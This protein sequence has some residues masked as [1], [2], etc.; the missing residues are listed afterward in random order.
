M[1]HIFIVNP[2]SG[3]GDCTGPLTKA[4]GPYNGKIDYEIYVT[5]K[6]G[7][8][9]EYVRERC[10][11]EPNTPKRFYACGGD[12]SLNEVTS[13]LVGFPNASAGCYP[14]GSGNDFVKYYGG[15]EKFLDV[16]SLINGEEM[17]VDIMR[18]GGR[19]S[20]NVCNFGFDA[21]VAS[22]M[23]K[24]RR[25]KLLGGPRAYFA[26]VG[27]SFINAMKHSCSV[28]VDGEEIHRGN[29]LLCTISNGTY[30]GG[31]YNCAPRSKNNDGYLEVCLVKTISR[32]RFLKLMNPYK[33]GKHL[34]DPNFKDCL[35]YRRGRKIEIT[36]P[37]GFL[38]SLDGEI[39]SSSH[40]TVEN[41]E[42]A[43]KFIVPR[44]VPANI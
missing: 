43:V 16:D 38:V 27:T 23:I 34:D 31:S 24:F 9:T 15:R 26:A 41:L 32:P 6:E 35:V 17:D 21:S 7:D 13:G 36:A 39:I 33:D 3:P 20:I 42:R 25:T 4:L 28:S 18:I 11:K 1:K 19:Y 14:T 8:A 2:K 22:R 30:V 12:G 37:E 44:G 40:F 10:V 29:F 5:S